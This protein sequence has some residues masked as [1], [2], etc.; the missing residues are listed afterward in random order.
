MGTEQDIDIQP[1][2]KHT[3]YSAVSSFTSCGE[4]YRLNKVVHAPEQGAWW[5]SGGTAVHSVTEAY[6]LADLVRVVELGWHRRPLRDRG[7]RPR[8]SCR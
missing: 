1:R 7:V 8:G 5:S 2:P 4:K 3:S 6:D